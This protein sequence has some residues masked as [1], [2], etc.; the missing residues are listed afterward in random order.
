MAKFWVVQLGERQDGGLCDLEPEL[1]ACKLFCLMKGLLRMCRSLQLLRKESQRRKFGFEI[2][3]NASKLR[4]S[5]DN[6]EKNAA[7]YI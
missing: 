2:E 3:K 1:R 7:G 6:I 4:E 5:V